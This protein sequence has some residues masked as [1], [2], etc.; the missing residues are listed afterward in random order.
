MVD[1]WTALIGRVLKHDRNVINVGSGCGTND[2]RWLADDNGIDSSPDSF[3]V[4]RKMLATARL[5]FNTTVKSSQVYANE[6][7]LVVS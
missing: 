2:A 4:N 3:S 6:V 1:E 5:N 7:L